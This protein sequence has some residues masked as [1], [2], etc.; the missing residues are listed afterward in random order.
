MKL[1]EVKTRDPVSTGSP[2]DNTSLLRAEMGWALEYDAG[3][4][5]A[6]KG[7]HHLLIPVSNV[8][9]MRPEA[10]PVGKPLKAA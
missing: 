4:V 3:L 7:G 5:T 6:R 1:D 9:C 8:A 10:A 2:G